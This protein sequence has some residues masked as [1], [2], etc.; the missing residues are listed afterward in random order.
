[1]NELTETV[2]GSFLESSSSP[3]IISSL[4]KFSNPTNNQKSKPKPLTSLTIEQVRLKYLNP[5]P[6]VKNSDLVLP[7]IEQKT[8]TKTQNRTDKTKLSTILVDFSR[9][10]IG[11]FKD[12]NNEKK[13]L[14]TFDSN[15]HST[16]SNT[17]SQT[18]NFVD[19][20]FTISEV[21]FN[22]PKNF[23][24]QKNKFMYKIEEDEQIKS[25]NVQTNYRLQRLTNG[26]HNSKDKIDGKKAR[27]KSRKKKS[28]L[29]KIQNAD[30]TSKRN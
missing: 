7:K 8:S 6:K 16:C 19:K 15:A 24:N 4:L 23:I 18:E 14:P 9:H 5:K 29:R 2:M 22:F 27:S 25:E 1:M 12:I 21:N 10:S 13:N 17:S 30:S 26:E 11:S 20:N 3:N 28:R